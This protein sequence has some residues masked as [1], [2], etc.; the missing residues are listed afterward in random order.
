M[1]RNSVSPE[2]QR[3]RDRN[4]RIALWGLAC[5]VLLLGVVKTFGLAEQGDG[6][7]VILSALGSLSLAGLL[8]WQAHQLRDTGKIDG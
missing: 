1:N 3:F 7:T 2:V 4:N 8:A 6:T 5:L